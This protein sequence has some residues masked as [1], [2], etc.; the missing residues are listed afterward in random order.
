MVSGCTDVLPAESDGAAEDGT[1]N[2]TEEGDGGEE[3]TD[4]ETPVTDAKTGSASDAERDAV[5]RVL[6]QNV[7][8]TEEQRLQSLRETLHPESPYYERT[9]QQTQ[10]IWNQYELKYS[11]TVQS[12]S[13]VGDEATVEYEQVTRA[14]GSNSG[15]FRD[16]RITATARLRTYRSEWRLYGTEIGDIEYLD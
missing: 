2:D 16:N 1:D 11:L 12:V 13:V 4:G 5:E 7:R 8:A 14:T 15:E 6:R 9:I 3:D 10:Q